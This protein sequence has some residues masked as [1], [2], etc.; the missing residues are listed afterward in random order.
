MNDYTA[1]ATGETSEETVLDGG[2]KLQVKRQSKLPVHISKTSGIRQLA[3]SRHA[4]AD[5]SLK[6]QVPV[7]AE[8]GVHS[9]RSRDKENKK[10][11][12]MVKSQDVQHR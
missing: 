2:N 5:Q 1:S 10:H 8:N 6:N 7:P 4:A 12:T 3:R 9:E 11:T